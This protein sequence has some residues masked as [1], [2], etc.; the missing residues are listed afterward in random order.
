MKSKRN[1]AALTLKELARQTDSILEGDGGIEITGAA[2]I[3]TAIAGE[4]TF[5]ANTKYLKFLDST[6]ASAVVLDKDTPCSQVAVIR[7][8]NPYLTFAKVLD[9]LY[10]ESVDVAVGVDKSSVV[11]PDAQISPEASIGPLCHIKDG[12]VVGEGSKLVSGVFLGKNVSVGKNCILYPG[13]CIMDDCC[14]GDNV[15]IHSSTVIGSDGFG[16]AESEN[17]LKK[18][19]Q[20]GWVEI[21]DDVEIGSNCSVDRGALG[22][23]VIGKGTKIDN[24]V[25]IGH[26][27]EVGRHCIIVSQVGISGST[28]LGN[29]VILAGQVGIV[30]HIEIGDGVKIGAQSGVSHSIPPGKSYFGYPAREIGQTARIEAALVHL[31]ELLK[32]VRKIEKKLP[33]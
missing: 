30:G 1:S 22:P 7:N 20:V 28:K 16:F 10:P 13:V 8:P 11:A 3:H 23:T 12:V 19:K 25:Q 4:I 29:G 21:G 27:V 31:P 15:I 33:D 18:I 5:V 24:L 6:K 26:N 17:G 14:I 9:I 2:P 32:R